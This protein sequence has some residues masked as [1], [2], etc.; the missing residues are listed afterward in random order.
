VT[1]TPRPPRAARYRRDVLSFVRVRMTGPALKAPAP[2]GTLMDTC[3][4]DLRY[5]L[6]GFRRRPLFAATAALTLTLGF[7]GTSPSSP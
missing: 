3:L 2:R 4:Q 6:R 5:A 7:G 1:S